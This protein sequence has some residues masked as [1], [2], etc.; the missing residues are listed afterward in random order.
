MNLLSDE[1]K[2]RQDIITLA[3]IYGWSGDYAEV[4]LFV[5]W[6]GEE[7]KMPIAQSDLTPFE[8]EEI[9]EESKKAKTNNVY[10]DMWPK[11][12]GLSF[13]IFI[14]NMNFCNK[15]PHFL[16]PTQALLGKEVFKISEY[17]TVPL[18]G[19]MLI[20]EPIDQDLR[21]FRLNN[22]DRLLS[23]WHGDININKCTDLLIKN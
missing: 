9:P 3:K 12:T 16:A 5:R 2:F 20:A 18:N 13:H 14:S 22:R 19:D 11:E 7:L 4:A 17:K 23:F 1:K 15:E 10:F 6:I 8:Y 21:K